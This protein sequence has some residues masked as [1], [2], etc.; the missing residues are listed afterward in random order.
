M[1][2]EWTKTLLSGPPLALS[3][4]KTLLNKSFETSLD[5]ALESEAQAQSVNLASS[6]AREA[7]NAFVEKRPPQFTGR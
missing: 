7:L 3:M 4:S 1:V 5:Q 6:D 2:S